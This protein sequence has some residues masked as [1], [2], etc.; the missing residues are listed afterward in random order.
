MALQVAALLVVG[1]LLLYSTRVA[2][3]LRTYVSK[4]FDT[5]TQEVTL[6]GGGAALPA[7]QPWQTQIGELWTYLGDQVPTFH[8]S[9][10]AIV[11]SC[12]VAG[13]VF[14][15]LMPKAARS[16]WA[17]TLGTGLFIAATWALLH[18]FWPVAAQAVGQ[19]GIFIAAT[20]WAVS[21]IW[22][23]VDLVGPRKV[24][25]PADAVERVAT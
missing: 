24:R 7:M 15:G 19:W 8:A 2:E 21:L 20:L 11:V 13:L 12:G 17:A 5:Q 14:A 23:M 3:P 10:V 18:T 6:P 22:N 16:F 1:A 25:P 4:E 9:F